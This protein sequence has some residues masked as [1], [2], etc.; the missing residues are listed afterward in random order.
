G[1]PGFVTSDWGAT[2]STVA[3]ANS[4]LDQQMPHDEFFGAALKTAVQNGQVSQARLNDMTG[5]I[6][7]QMFTF[8]LFDNAPRGSKDA[9]VRTADH[10]AVAQQ[11]AAQGSVLLKNANVLPLD[12]AHSIA[13]LG[14]DGDAGAQTISSGG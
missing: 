14:D 8:G 1:F 6:L 3:A 10:L 4:G 7:G 13:V 11:V 2:H 9:V 5:R 12:S